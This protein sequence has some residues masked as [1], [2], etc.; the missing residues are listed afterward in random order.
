M[1]KKDNRTHL[2]YKQAVFLVGAVRR[3]QF[4]PDYGAEVAFAGRSN[5]GKSSAINMITGIRS[6]AR[7]SK[8]PGRTQQINFFRL[9]EERRLV[10]LP[11]YGYSKAPEK[12]RRTWGVMVE[13]YLRY[14]QSLRGVALLMD[15]RRPLTDLDRQLVDWC[16]AAGL[17]FHIVLTKCDK[18]SL[19]RARTARGETLRRLVPSGDDADVL[20]FSAT[21]KQGIDEVR[22]YLTGWLD[23]P[24]M[25]EARRE[26]KSARDDSDFH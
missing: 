24:A 25:L 12:L 15:A 3:A 20:L 11:G 14:R 6:L 26:R 21:Q 2:L 5:V 22:Q 17:P 8:T 4:P 9:D 18:L 23:N 10:D 7:T 16:L 13:D 19:S 1:F